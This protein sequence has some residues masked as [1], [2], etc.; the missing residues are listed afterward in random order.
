MF[1]K[2][3]IRPLNDPLYATQID[4]GELIESLIFYKKVI[5]PL[6]YSAL[7]DLVLQLG[8]ETLVQLIQE[9]YLQIEYMPNQVGVVT[10]TRGIT[11]MHGPLI[12][13]SPK[14]VL[15]NAT[16]TIMQEITGKD[17]KGRRQGNRL[18]EIIAE[19]EV[20]LS[21]LDSIKSDFV[22]KE[23][24]SQVIKASISH[25]CPSYPNLENLSYELEKVND[26]YVA[27]SNINFG[28]ANGIY[29][30]TISPKHSS[31]THGHL[32]N[33]LTNQ[34]LNFHLASKHESEIRVGKLDSDVM[35]INFTDLIKK[36]V[37][38]QANIS[39]FADFTL[40]NGNAIRESVLSGQK[41]VAE[42][43]PLIKKAD[44]FKDWLI[45][46]PDDA[47]LIKEYYKEVT[48]ESFVDKLP[49]KTFRFGIFSAGGMVIDSLGAGG[50]GTLAGLSLSALDTFILDKLLKGWK[51]NQFVEEQLKK[52]LI[53]K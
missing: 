41:N 8:Y 47:N 3:C 50:L 34:K 40:D 7:K 16:V 46:Q 37:K 18:T 26:Q 13:S 43:L 42:F 33:K 48:A 6:N 4:I 21:I 44:K 20:P 11:Q 39:S 15:Q 9:G 25:E 35:K 28:I 51:P 17:G 52:E 12:F 30:K 36:S 22:N 19:A 32:L 49:S 38:S 45:K 24:V 5:L 27:H 1:N 23:Y 53:K 31:I 2:V 14:Q 10:N 29:H